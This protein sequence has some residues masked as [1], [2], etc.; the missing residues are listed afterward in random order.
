LYERDSS[1]AN[2]NAVFCRATIIQHNTSKKG[3]ATME[4]VAVPGVIRNS[5]NGPPPYY[6][7]RSMGQAQF[8]TVNSRS[9]IQH[10]APNSSRVSWCCSL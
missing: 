5:T 6:D 8:P 9:G 3:H 1:L 10:F 4:S 7:V 2:Q